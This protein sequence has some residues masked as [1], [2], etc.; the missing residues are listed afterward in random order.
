MPHGLTTGK[1]V[2]DMIREL[3]ES[4]KDSA[5]LSLETRKHREMVVEWLE[6]M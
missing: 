6:K 5:K 2:L 1:N 3:R 4:C